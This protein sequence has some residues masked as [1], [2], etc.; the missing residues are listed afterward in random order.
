M[1]LFLAL[2]MVAVDHAEARR[3][4]S[5]GSRGMRTFQAAPPTRTAPQQTAPVQ[6]SMTPGTAQQPGAAARQTQPNAARPGFFNGMG[7]SLMRGLLIGGLI[8]MLLGQGFGGLAGLFGLLVQGL[9]IGLV[10]MLVIRFFRSRQ[11]GGP[12][13][14]GAASGGRSAGA[15]PDWQRNAAREQAGRPF[16]VPGIGS[17]SGAARAAAPV[18]SRDLQLDGSDLDTFEQRLSEVQVAFTREDHA[19]LR[20]LLT[21]EMVSYFS[22]ELA[23]NAQRGVRNDVSD[24]TLLQADI[25]ESWSEGSDDYATAALRYEA[26]DRMLDRETGEIVEGDDAPSETT[27]LW[28]FTRSRGGEWKLSA[29]QEA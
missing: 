22:E 13:Y 28:T 24:V 3:G 1:G 18:Q 8:G 4:G 23:Q 6:R 16:Q 12:A 25:A 27:E 5:F 17:G 11:Q 26:R 21:P 7:G 2:S 29:I 14:A 15:S 19:A 20:R 10:I 9:L